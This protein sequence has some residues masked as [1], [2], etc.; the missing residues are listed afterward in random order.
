MSNINDRKHRTMT[1]LWHT[2]KAAAPLFINLCINNV[3]IVIVQVLVR[4]VYFYKDMKAQWNK[5]ST[6]NVELFVG[7]VWKKS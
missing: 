7:R 2:S 5:K 6:V 4:Y 3:V 1:D